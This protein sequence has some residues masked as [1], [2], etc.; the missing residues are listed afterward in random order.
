MSRLRAIWRVLNM[1][2]EEMTR[3]ASESLDRDLDP[4][5]SFALRS[6][7]LYCKDCRRYRRQ[8]EFLRGVMRRLARNVE[9]DACSLGLGLPEAVRQRIKR[10]INTH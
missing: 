10:A 3:L 6:H 2:C 5:E 1:P 9:A 8:I 4:L 7:L